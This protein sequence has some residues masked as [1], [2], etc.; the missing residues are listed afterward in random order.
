MQKYGYTNDCSYTEAKEK[1][2]AEEKG[3]LRLSVSHPSAMV[4]LAR[5]NL[6]LSSPTA[7]QPPAKGYLLKKESTVPLIYLKIGSEKN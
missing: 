1:A 3:I 7:A 2:K 5:L 6:L 4:R